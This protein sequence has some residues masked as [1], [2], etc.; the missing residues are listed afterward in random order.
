MIASVSSDDQL[1]AS[2]RGSDT[3]IEEVTELITPDS[4]AIITTK[5]KKP[6][7]STRAI[8][9]GGQLLID[10]ERKVKEVVANQHQR[11]GE[12]ISPRSR[13]SGARAISDGADAKKKSAMPMIVSTRVLRSFIRFK[14]LN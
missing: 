8:N 5:A 13:K 3:S 10:A 6:T 14:T 2:N 12:N 11:P 4:F 7:L 1:V 9:D